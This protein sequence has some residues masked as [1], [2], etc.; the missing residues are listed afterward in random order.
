MEIVRKNSIN[1]LQ[2]SLD[3]RYRGK[4]ALILKYGK[5][6]EYFPGIT[7]FLPEGRDLATHGFMM[8]K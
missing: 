4:G 3:D 8:W 6:G 2:T 5:T 7:L 1:I